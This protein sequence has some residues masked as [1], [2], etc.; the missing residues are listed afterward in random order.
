MTAAK[1][2]DGGRGD[3]ARGAETTLSGESDE[4][5]SPLK[6][7]LPRRGSF[8]MLQVEQDTQLNRN[9]GCQMAK[10]DSFLS[11]DCTRVEGLRGR[12]KERKG[13][14]FAA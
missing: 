9:Q 3:A 7:D 10:F 12:S 8:K 14:N 5:E 6:G 1:R 2:A 4:V 13:S 11:L